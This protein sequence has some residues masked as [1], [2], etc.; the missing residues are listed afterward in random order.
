MI[1]Q[2]LNGACTSKFHSSKNPA[3]IMCSLR[4]AMQK[5]ASFRVFNMLVH[6]YLGE[7][8]YLEDVSIVSL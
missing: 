8:V 1:M 2:C 5:I 3:M 6:A 4:N 7:H